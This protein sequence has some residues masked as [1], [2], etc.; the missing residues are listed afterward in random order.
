MLVINDILGLNREFHPRFVRQYADLNSVIEVE[1]VSKHKMDS[2]YFNI[3]YQT[4][5]E[6]NE[7]KV[8]NR[9]A[10]Y[11]VAIERVAE[12]MKLRGWYQASMLG[13]QRTWDNTKNC[14][15][16]PINPAIVHRGRA[17]SFRRGCQDQTIYD[18]GSR[19]RAYRDRTIQLLPRCRVPGGRNEDMGL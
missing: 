19:S 11:I 12:A 18:G 14:F 15:R 7:T 3:P 8:N 17:S 9:M 1:D 16:V 5:M 10:A 13:Y 6:I 4:A 2:E